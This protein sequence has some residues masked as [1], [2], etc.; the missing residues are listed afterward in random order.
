[1]KL[2][3]AALGDDSEMH[4]ARHE[5]VDTLVKYVACRR[6]LL[7]GRRVSALREYI[8]VARRSSIAVRCITS[9]FRYNLG[10]LFIFVR[11]RW[12]SALAQLIIIKW[13]QWPHS[14]ARRHVTCTAP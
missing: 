13:H 11:C 4:L 10:M 5:S 3:S 14:S 7:E 8:S 6:R 12:K 2:E 1:M 9:A